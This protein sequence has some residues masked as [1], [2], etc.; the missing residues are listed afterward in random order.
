LVCN[1]ILFI[2]VYASY[3]LSQKVSA[4][5]VASYAHYYV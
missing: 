4:K 5:L 2:I 1:E 3:L